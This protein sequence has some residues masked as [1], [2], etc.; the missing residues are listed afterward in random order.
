A[1]VVARSAPP[2]GCPRGGGFFRA[3]TPDPGPGGRGLL[4]GSARLAFRPFEP[5]VA[6]A[7]RRNLQHVP[8]LHEAA[9]RYP[10]D[11]GWDRSHR[12]QREGAT[13]DGVS[14]TSPGIAG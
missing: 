13:E 4:H 3:R 5:N 12:R 2:V 10:A 8:A 1:L 6:L 7:P 11:H 9:H 14:R